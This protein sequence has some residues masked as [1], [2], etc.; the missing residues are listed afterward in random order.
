VGLVEPHASISSQTLA[1]WMK[2]LLT[3]AGIDASVWK[4]HSVRS[5]SSA[6]L[7]ARKNLDLLQVCKLADWAKVS[8][9]YLKFYHRYT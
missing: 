6:H 2:I 1:R 7:R 3:S 5:A 4:P 9:T 8:G